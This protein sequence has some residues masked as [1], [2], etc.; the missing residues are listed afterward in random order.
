MNLKI[1]GIYCIPK[2]YQYVYFKIELFI[3]GASNGTQIFVNVRQALSHCAP[4]FS[5]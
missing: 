3:C 5:P 2:R 1:E 4:I